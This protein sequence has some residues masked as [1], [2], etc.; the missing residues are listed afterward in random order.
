MAT[1]EQILS[2]LN[3]LLD[4]EGVCTYRKK[5]GIDVFVIR[6]KDDE[7]TTISLARD[8]FY[9]TSSISNER[10]FE[11][12]LPYQY[13]R[14]IYITE[15][16]R[17]QK[18]RI[19]ALKGKENHNYCLDL[20]M[21]GMYSRLSVPLEGKFS[22]SFIASFNSNSETNPSDVHVYICAKK[23]EDNDGCSYAYA[24]SCGGIVNTKTVIM[25]NCGYNRACVT[26]AIEAIESVY[27]TDK[28]SDVRIVIHC[29]CNYL[30]M[31]YN[32]WLAGWIK[33]DGSIDPEKKNTDLW[34]KLLVLKEKVRIIIP[35]T[36]NKED[37]RKID[38]LSEGIK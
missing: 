3:R 36:V 24:I 38:E 31:G 32:Y 33:E 10:A 6:S 37:M 5:K 14:A 20:Y 35:E 18:Q 8:Y 27:D 21:N 30:V 25:E 12:N 13:I 9:Q 26:A 16:K 23:E 29:N 1:R 11:A 7:S 34:E 22:E 28:D 4:V 2:K 17:E 19:F 15:R